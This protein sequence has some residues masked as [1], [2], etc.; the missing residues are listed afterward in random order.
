[1]DTKRIVITGGPG[2]GKTTIINELIK[3]KYVCLEEI[4]RQVTLE[5]QERGI[6]QLFLTEPLLF[7]DMLLEGRIQQFFEAEKFDSDF[8]FFDRGVP[9]VVAY[10]DYLKT[11]YPNRFNEACLN[12]KYDHIFILAPWQEIYVSDN[13]RYENYEQAVEIHHHLL[14]AYARYGYAMHDVPFGAVED[15]ADYIINLA[16]KL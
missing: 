3:R 4:S 15:R 9:D 8:I 10:M 2:T 11:S 6:D 1:M 14:A 5:A 16:K 13:E 7:S 12:N